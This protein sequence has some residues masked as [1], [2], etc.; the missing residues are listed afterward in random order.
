M[1]VFRL[2]L[3]LSL[4]PLH[5]VFSQR[6]DT[7]PKDPIALWETINKSVI[8]LNNKDLLEKYNLYALDIQSTAYSETQKKLIY[9]T[10]AILWGRKLPL[11]PYITSY[12]DFVA[13][14]KSNTQNVDGFNSWHTS[15]QSLLALPDKYT[16]FK[17]NDFL[18]LSSSFV[19]RQLISSGGGANWTLK[20]GKYS[21]EW[22]NQEPK[23]SFTK[24]QLST[25]YKT[26]TIH[27]LETSGVLYPFKNQWIGVGGKCDWSRVGLDKSVF[28]LLK[29]YS[30]DLN[31]NKF[32]ADS[33]QLS[34]P[35]YFGK[36]L[37]TIL[38]WLNFKVYF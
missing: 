32:K 31:L 12:L 22:E 17:I 14:L 33:V 4:L 20:G 5:Y 28:V 30:L 21:W 19:G 34:Y 24:A 27:I 29:N 23:L 38:F 13:L 18:T 3:I 7:L 16:P 2:V 6:V 35:S 15:F 8:S 10:L 25:G 9:Q 26:D 11:I 37:I 1:R 36:N